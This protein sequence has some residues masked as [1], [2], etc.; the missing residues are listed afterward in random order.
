MFSPPTSEGSEI[1]SDQSSGF[2]LPPP[3]FLELAVYL[4]KI[5]PISSWGMSVNVRHKFSATTKTSVWGKRIVKAF[6]VTQFPSCFQTSEKDIFNFFFFVIKSCSLLSWHLTHLRTR[7][8]L[9]V[10]QHT[11]LVPRTTSISYP[12]PVT[13]YSLPY[14]AFLYCPFSNKKPTPAPS[15]NAVA[16]GRLHKG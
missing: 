5:L 3:H 11:L 1:F 8:C 12:F 9:P 2:S 10:S 7:A 6:S 13:Q 15:Q 4:K 16:G 14:L